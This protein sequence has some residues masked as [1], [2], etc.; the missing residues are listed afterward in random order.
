MSSGSSLLGNKTDFLCCF[1]ADLLKTVSRA[2]NSS[3]MLIRESTHLVE[4]VNKCFLVNIYVHMG[5]MLDPEI[6]LLLGYWT[7]SPF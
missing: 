5:S 2:V 1:A 6:P 7:S 3:K 4:G